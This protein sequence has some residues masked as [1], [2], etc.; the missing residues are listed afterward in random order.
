M[1]QILTDTVSDYLMGWLIRMHCQGWAIYPGIDELDFWSAASAVEQQ[2]RQLGCNSKTWR[3][4]GIII[5]A[6]CWCWAIVHLEYSFFSLLV[7]DSILSFW[8]SVYSLSTIKQRVRTTMMVIVLIYCRRAW[9]D[10]VWTMWR[11]YRPGFS[12][13]TNPSNDRLRRPS[14]WMFQANKHPN[15]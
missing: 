13:G 1:K 10:S 6:L 9:L 2:N 3:S 4:A 11:G 5:L 14:L 8:L 15:P 12:V 7:L